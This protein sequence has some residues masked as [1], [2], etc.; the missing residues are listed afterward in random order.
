MT[1]STAPLPPSPLDV[2][3][4]RWEPAAVVFDCDGVLVNTEAEWVAVQ[5]EYLRSHGVELDDVTRRRITGGSVEFVVRSLAEHVGRTPEQVG[6]ELMELHGDQ[7]EHTLVPMPGVMEL[8]AAVASRKPVAV[9]SNSP[10]ELL[11]HKLTALGIAELVDASVAIE[12]VAEPKPAPDIYLRAAEVLGAA[13]ADTLGIED[14]ETGA[15]AALG[16]GL[17]LLAV[18]SIPGQSPRAPRRIAALTD[19]VLHEWVA[20]WSRTR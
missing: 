13:P 3:P 19:P 15:D 11:D 8:L 17:Q 4:P 12:D 18:P 7:R 2:W 16:A 14:S 6:A 1:S 10:R 9:A 5:T 20:S